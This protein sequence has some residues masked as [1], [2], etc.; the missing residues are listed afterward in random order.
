MAF[1]I[2]GLIYSLIKP[3]APAGSVNLPVQV[4]VNGPNT[5]VSVS[6][7]LLV[8][9]TG[10]GGAAGLTPAPAAGDAA[11][12]KFLKADGTF[13]VPASAS[14]LTT[15]GDLFGHSTVDARIPVGAD[16]TVLTA[17]STQTLGVK[18]AAPAA[19]ITALTGDVTASGPGSAAATL[20]STAVT[21][22]SYTNA[23]V[24]VDAK[25]RVTAA[26]N[27]S[28][29]PGSGLIQQIQFST[30]QSTSG[31]VTA[32]FTNAVQ[33]GS[34]VVVEYVGINNVTAISDSQG[35]GYTQ[36]NSQSWT[37]LTFVSQFV[38]VNVVG[39]A[40]ITVTATGTGSKAILNVYEY[41]N[42]ASVDTSISAQSGV[43]GSSIASGTM[44]TSLPGDLVHMTGMA[45]VAA[46]SSSNSGGWPLIQSVVWVAGGLVVSSYSTT[47]SAAG[48]VSNTFS[49]SPG[50]THNYIGL[51][52]LK[53]RA[54]LQPAVTSL[55]TAGTSGPATLAGGV[56]N[57]PNYA[58]GGG[59][60][61]AAIIFPGVVASDSIPDLSTW[62][63]VNSAV[64]VSQNGGAGFPALFKITNNASVNWRAL[65]TAI[66]STPYTIRVRLNGARAFANSSDLG[67][68]WFDATNKM[69]GIEVLYQSSGTPTVRVHKGTSPTVDTSDTPTASGFA[70]GCGY[71]AITQTATNQIYWYSPDGVN[72][73]QLLS[74][75]TGTFMTPT[76]YGVGGIAAGTPDIYGSLT[77][78][79]QSATNSP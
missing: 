60:G 50:T 19:A 46:T 34:T 77:Y 44:T 4:D 39:G 5:T 74:E 66:P 7:P 23:S 31:T 63:A 73:I 42:V 70:D 12:G 61:G 64:L 18:Y 15:K 38:A 78:F 14:P 67:L 76:G 6:A 41:S 22:G 33:P 21:P 45:D 49:Y 69:A 25:G 3:A 32:T 13:A 53:P 16:G 2:A 55:T 26:S 58:T 30:G 1:N 62:T 8:G 57:I 28:V 24:T 29:A 68:Y 36:F 65:K 9:D 20:A 17:D 52:A 35:N 51:L 79:R 40:A 75:A 54:V 59:G 72:W 56:L 27:G 43:G 11:A 48:S 10:S 71:L 47:Q 37:G